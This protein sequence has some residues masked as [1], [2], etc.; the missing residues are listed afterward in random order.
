MVLFCSTIMAVPPPVD[1]PVVGYRGTP[2]GVLGLLAGFYGRWI[3]EGIMRVLDALMAFPTILLYMI[4]ISA[5]GPSSVNVVIAMMIG[6]LGSIPG[7][8]LG[9]LVLG[10]LEAHSQWYFGPQIRD[11]SAYMLLFVC[12][13]LRPGGLLGEAPTR[14]TTVDRR[15]A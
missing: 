2:R 4:I 15:R 9:G 14:E 13:V 8:I 11:L 12:L 10:C 6:G 7:A 5:V 3:D 1:R